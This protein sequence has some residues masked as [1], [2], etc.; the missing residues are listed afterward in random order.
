MHR[1]AVQ[2][3]TH[4]NVVYLKLNRK[5]NWCS[6]LIDIFISLEPEWTW[7][8]V[9]ILL[10]YSSMKNWIDFEKTAF[11]LNIF[12]HNHSHVQPLLKI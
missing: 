2:T 8:G 12:S 11:V 1:Y 9:N 5:M 3:I 10:W 7:Y 6:P 4:L